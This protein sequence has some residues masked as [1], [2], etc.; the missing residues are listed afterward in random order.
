[1]SRRRLQWLSASAERT[2]ALGAAL[3]RGRP[4]ASAAPLIVHL[5]GELG[6]GKT[7]LARGFLHACGVA[8]AVRSPTYTLVETYET[9]GLTLVHADLYRLHD[10]EELEGLGL[11]DLA[12]P[13]CLWLVEWPEHGGERLPAPDLRIELRIRPGG[14]H[15]IEARACTASGDAWLAA[16]EL[17]DGEP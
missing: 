3:A 9:A 4:A 1:M 15:A 10:P 16:V 14:A 5:R 7:T 12:R 2:E 13:G 8:G 17:A 6:A 11:R